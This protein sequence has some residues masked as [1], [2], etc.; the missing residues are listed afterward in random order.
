MAGTVPETGGQ[1]QDTV[2][3]RKN[4]DG[5]SPAFGALFVSDLLK[6]E[7]VSISSDGFSLCTA[8]CSHAFPVVLDCISWMD[9]IAVGPFLYL[10]R[11][12]KSN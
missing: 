10:V 2:E 6:Y 1:E 11:A 3:K 5:L 4:R 9:I 12:T 8:A 7:W